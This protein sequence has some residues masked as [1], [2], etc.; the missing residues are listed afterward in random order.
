[1]D[2]EVIKTIKNKYKIDPSMA[3]RNCDSMLLKIYLQS[4]SPLR[5]K[6]TLK[7]DPIEA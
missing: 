7:L 3:K 5:N 1:M 2:K 6:N 4:K